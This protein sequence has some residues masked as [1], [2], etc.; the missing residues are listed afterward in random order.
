[1]IT[2]RTGEELDSVM[3]KSGNI[4]ERDVASLEIG[5][6]G[7][8]TLVYQTIRKENG[9]VRPSVI[10]QTTYFVM[11][12]TF[13]YLSKVKEAGFKNVPVPTF[14]GWVSEN[15]NKTIVDFINFAVP[16][17]ERLNSMEE[18]VLGLESVMSFVFQDEILFEQ[19]REQEEI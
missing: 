7:H 5:W 10:K 11:K 8:I 1:M 2:L 6:T 12:A 14:T 13:E 9:N 19:D 15:L 3:A 18:W 17:R 4:T 16:V